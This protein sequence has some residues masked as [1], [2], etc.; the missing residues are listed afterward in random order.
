[1]CVISIKRQWVRV[2]AHEVQVP[3]RILAGFKSHLS[4]AVSSHLRPVV[5]FHLHL[6]MFSTPLTDEFSP[7]LNCL[8]PKPKLRHHQ[9]IRPLLQAGPLSFSTVEGNLLLPTSEP[10]VG[11]P[12]PSQ[13]SGTGSSPCESLQ[14]SMSSHTTL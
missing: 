9:E 12:T 6:D 14:P 1:M 3:I 7:E 2:P 8:D 11:V 10:S 5:R 13:T 4:C